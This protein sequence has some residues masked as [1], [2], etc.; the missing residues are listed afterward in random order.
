MNTELQATIECLLTIVLPLIILYL[1]GNWPLRVMV[2]CLVTVPILWYLTYA[3]LHE[4]SHVAGAYLAGGS[5]TFIKL[6]PRFWEGEFARAWITTAGIDRPWQH[7]ICTGFPY[8]L[9]VVSAAIG[10]GFLRGRTHIGPF[11]MGLAF[12]LLC[13]R[14][15]FDILCEIVGYAL[16]GMGDIYHIALI[17]GP[18]MTW[19]LALLGLGVCVAATVG[20]LR[21]HVRVAPAQ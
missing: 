11:I 6:I 18:S 19:I 5:V 13:L 1:R 21:S 9:D 2:I 4:L 16:G 14:G 12:M 8:I 7:L 20:V 17:L 15:A 10:Y 3:P